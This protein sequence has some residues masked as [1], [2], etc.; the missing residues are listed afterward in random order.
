MKNF[1]LVTLVLPT[2]LAAP[3][4]LDTDLD[5]VSTDEELAEQSSAVVQG[6]VEPDYKHPWVVS[7]NGCH[8]VLV[9]PRW[10]L[11]A[12]HCVPRNGWSY[13]VAFSRTDPAS[14]QLHTA[15]R[16]VGYSGVFIHPAYQLGG[17][18]DSPRNDIALIRLDSPFTIDP[19]I[20][21]VA[22]PTAPRVIGRIGT[23]AAA[24]HTNAQLP[25]GFNA[26][27]RAPIPAQSPS[28]C[29]APDGAFCVSSPTAGLCHGDSG[30][31]FV[32]IEGGRATVTGI[33][34]YAKVTD[35]QTVGA[36]DYAGLTDVYY[37][38]DWILRTMGQ[39]DATLA[40]NT[41]V[42]WSGRAARGVFGVGCTNPYDTM[43]GPLGV[44]GA[45][46]GASCAAGDT[47]SVVCSMSGNQP[48][49]LALAIT[50]FKMRT[51]YA[52]G[53]V[54]V[55]SLPFGSSFASYY[56]VLP[57]GVVREFTCE[58]NSTIVVNP[59]GGVFAP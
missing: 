57:A 26:V 16:T 58:I 59:G 6:T 55:Q 10:V 35:C 17:G 5:A 39:S 40:G 47:Q 7:L 29:F 36:N 37:F 45:Q 38:R 23:I 18:F 34:S 46:V 49:P 41:R 14:G 56:G 44:V 12:A 30:S 21:T 19:Y 28:G 25:P 13:R 48:S 53:T 15:T 22:I 31:G 1:A 24:S 51:T 33:A 20:Q 11:T 4:C 50:G 8:G 32:T 52:N 43:W 27:L 42:R 2:L 3:G 9:E 54:S